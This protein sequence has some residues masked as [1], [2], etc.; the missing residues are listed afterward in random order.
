MPR[1]LQMLANRS[2]YIPHTRTLNMTSCARRKPS[3]IAMGP[4]LSP[5][6]LSWQTK[7]NEPPIHH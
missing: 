6:K 3:N 5:I 2:Q 4:F 7:D 1:V